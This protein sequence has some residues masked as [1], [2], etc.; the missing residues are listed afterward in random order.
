MSAAKKP[1]ELDLIDAAG[2][3]NERFVKNWISKGLRVASVGRGAESALLAASEQGHTQIVQ[4]LL[5]A[6]AYVNEKG[7]RDW[8]PVALAAKNG[9]LDV[10]KLLAAQGADLNAETSEGD[11][12]LSIASAAGHKSLA[13]FLEKAGARRI[14][15]EA[16]DD[17]AN[18]YAGAV[19]ASSNEDCT[20]RQRASAAEKAARLKANLKKRIAAG[21]QGG[22]Y[23]LW[24]GA[25]CGSK[26]VLELLLPA[27]ANVNAAPHLSSALSIACEDGHL[28]AVRVLLNA[29][30]NVNFGGTG[31][32]PILDAVA[33]GSLEI[34][35]ELIARRANVNVK[36][37]EG[38]TPLLLATAM[39]RSD[40]MKALLDAGAIPN[41]TGTVVIGERPPPEKQVTTDNLA[42]KNLSFSITRYPEP[43][44]ALNVTPL[45]VASRRN[46][47]EA[48]ELLL[49][50]NADK[51]AKDPEGLTAL[52]WAKRLGHAEIASIL[53]ASGA[54]ETS[55]E[56][57][58]ENSL[59]IAA[60]KGE[61]AS[62]KK[63]LKEGADPNARIRSPDESRTALCEA[64]A[65]GAAEIVQALLK[66]GAKPDE[67]TGKRTGPRGLTPLMLSAKGGHA[68]TVD[69]LLKGG[70]S[71]EAR[72]AEWVG[73]GWTP[74]HYAAEGGS[75][76]AVELILAA[77]A[78]AS[79]TDRE[80]ATPLH[81]AAKRGNVEAMKVLLKHT[82]IKVMMG[83]VSKVLSLAA[84]SQNIEAVKAV[85][86]ANPKAHADDADFASVLATRAPLE[87]IKVLKK[88]GMRF[89]KPNIGGTTPLAA[90][91]WAGRKD[92]MQFLRS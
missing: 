36:R 71:V 88:A 9:H 21:E 34:A 91:E 8:T 43:P 73:G 51:E 63:L 70:A 72:D 45:I 22:D 67:P 18:D 54:K 74:L 35:R 31:W 66:A 49:S 7:K 28:E 64:A 52:A 55:L 13:N 84:D 80:K 39:D 42:G 27:K 17:A 5:E 26:E 59:L 61:L 85:L 41:L 86:A 57:S 2:K 62:V 68:E 38:P 19:E 83:R 78:D 75:G 58:L 32:P 10:V 77:G 79:V 11:T 14:N 69:A 60:G 37:R 12:P 40:L 87:M 3:G 25:R 81:A 30:A 50:R 46:F 24:L 56:G 65:I 1:S 48:V 76:K 15:S 33:A 82:S 4:L 6:G 53:E 29:G 20:K 92:V 90:A 89:D 44:E 47:K 23:A 16:F